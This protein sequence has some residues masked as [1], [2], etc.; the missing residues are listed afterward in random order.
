MHYASQFCIYRVVRSYTRLLSVHGSPLEDE[1]AHYVAV[2]YRAGAFQSEAD[3]GCTQTFA[4]EL[5]FE[6]KMYVSTHVAV[7]NQT[8]VAFGVVAQLKDDTGELAAADAS[9]AVHERKV[10]HRAVK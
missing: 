3:S 4:V 7:G 8:L 2:L 6:I 9:F 10:L 1:I 5:V